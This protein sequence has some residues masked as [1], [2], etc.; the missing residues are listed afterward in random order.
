MFHVPTVVWA[1]RHVAF[2]SLTLSK[3]KRPVDP[4]SVFKCLKLC[5]TQNHS[6]YSGCGFRALPPSE[7]HLAGSVDASLQFLAGIAHPS[8]HSGL[9]S[10]LS[11]LIL[12]VVPLP[13]WHSMPT[14]PRF[15]FFHSSPL[16]FYHNINS[17]L[18]HCAS[19]FCYCQKKL[20]DNPLKKSESLLWVATV[21]VLVL[22]CLALWRNSAW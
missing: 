9:C 19:T 2:S 17:W 8:L 1:E 10:S 13:T 5:G 4:F 22:G 14:S 18:K 20:P 16:V 11:S 15:I 12:W 7:T 21:D 3:Y 6:M